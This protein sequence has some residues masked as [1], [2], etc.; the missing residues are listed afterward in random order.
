MNGSY[1]TI[2]S[3]AP[4]S[5]LMILISLFLFNDIYFYSFHSSS[6]MH[7]IIFRVVLRICR[8]SKVNFL[9]TVY[10]NNLLILNFLL[11]NLLKFVILQK[12]WHTS[13]KYDMMNYMQIPQGALEK[14]KDNIH[15]GEN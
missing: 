10:E 5:L 4:Q 2:L 1:Q 9:D 6:C 7:N 15:H 11:K 8:K 13:F 14:N 12:N 3:F